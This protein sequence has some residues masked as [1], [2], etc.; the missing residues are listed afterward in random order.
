MAYRP[1]SFGTGSSSQDYIEEE[2][3]DSTDDEEEFYEEEIEEEVIDEDDDDDNH[4]SHQPP[5]DPEGELAEDF[6]RPQSEGDLNPT[7]LSSGSTPG[8]KFSQQSSYQSGASRLSS[9][10]EDHALSTSSLPKSEEVTTMKSASGEVVKVQRATFPSS[11]F[12]FGIAILIILVA[13][14]IVTGVSI[15]GRN[16]KVLDPIEVPTVSPRPTSPGETLAPTIFQPTVSPTAFPTVSPETM[17]DLFARVVGE[18]VY[19]E[20]TSAQQAADW[21]LNQDPAQIPLSLE[22]MSQA[23]WEQRY[24]LVYLY[25][26]TTGNRQTEW[27]SCNPPIF[28]GSQTVDCE[29]SSP[30]ELPGGRLIFDR[31]P[32]NRWLSAAHECDWAGI[33]CQTVGGTNDNTETRLAVTS[34]N[35]AGQRLRGSIVTELVQLPEL[36]SLDLSH[37]GLAGTLD[38]VFKELQTLHLQYNAMTGTIPTSF[39][40]GESVM[41]RLNIGNN[42][43]NGTL[44]SE[45]NLASQLSALYVFEN[46]FVGTIPGL[47]KMPLQIFQ[48]QGNIFSGPLP[49]DLFFGTWAET[50]QEWW[51]FDNQ[52]TGELSSNM[53]LLLNLQDFRAGNNFFQGSIPTSTYQLSRLFRL[54]VNDNELTGAID[55]GISGLTSLEVFD[56]SGNALTGILPEE[57]GRL[58]SLVSVKTQN[59]LFSGTIPT[60]LCFLGSMEVLEADCLPEANPPVECFCCTTCCLKQT[61]LSKKTDFAID[62]MAFYSNDLYPIVIDLK[63][64]DNDEQGNRSNSSIVDGYKEKATTAAASILSGTIFCGYSD[65]SEDC[66]KDYYETKVEMSALTADRHAHELGK[67]RK[68]H[69]TET[70]YP[71]MASFRS[72][73]QQ[74]LQSSQ[75]TKKQIVFAEATIHPKYRQLEDDYV[76]TQQI[77]RCNV[78]TLW[79][80]IHRTSGNRYCVKAIDKRRFKT[81]TDKETALREISMYR[82]LFSNGKSVPSIPQL[83]DVLEDKN[84]YY[85]VQEYEAGGGNLGLI[86]RDHGPLSEAQMRLFTSALLEA[87]SKLHAQSICHNDLHPENVLIRGVGSI[88]EVL[89]ATAGNSHNIVKICDL[90]RSLCVKYHRSDDE[91]KCQTRH[92]SLYYIAPEIISGNSPGLASDMWSIGVMLYVCFCGY[93]P[94][95]SDPKL[96]SDFKRNQ[97]KRQICQADYTFPGSSRHWALVSRSAKQFISSL[98]HPDPVVRMTCHE[99][100]SHPWLAPAIGKMAPAPPRSS[101]RKKAGISAPND[102]NAQLPQDQGTTHP[103][104]AEDASTSD[105]ISHNRR[106]FVYRLWGKIKHKKHRAIK[107]ETD[108]TT[109]SSALS[110]SNS[111]GATAP[112][113]SVEPSVAGG[114]RS[115]RHKSL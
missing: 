27:L 11:G 81:K 90:G 113:A 24:L 40:D 86:L 92:S 68:Q 84:H 110:S 85:I 32:S 65:T 55:R 54:E 60:D 14:G 107:S 33:S 87:V 23:A 106:S 98:L 61:S 57:L 114:H 30:T 111:A 19:V 42:F 2:V 71:P 10:H 15:V 83:Y 62:K 5:R 53:G 49:F 20:G 95:Q 112:D 17:L 94:F 78:A 103:L 105:L 74:H 29:F 64:L 48:G 115:R 22:A 89:V 100:L 73:S 102:P 12:L 1:S 67:H 96:A 79:E 9:V 59:N 69:H 72:S 91:A 51:V 44:P 3:H 108:I 39:F 34:I 4:P 45:V 104:K 80:C 6:I 99:A 13:A 47:G 50:I 75:G 41:T 38:N 31:V 35:L 21:M 25:Y 97:L 36:R 52:L 82:S 43:M 46:N 16:K 26:A 88:N 37:N 77:V 28:V 58:P 63:D 7:S 70:P 66:R 18:D 56:V 93:H 8:R 76:L 109:T 101:F